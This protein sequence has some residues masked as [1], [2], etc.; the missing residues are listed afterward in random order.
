LRIKKD[1]VMEST[2]HR[3]LKEHYACGGAEV[4]VPLQKFR[5]DVMTD[6][7]LIEIQHSGLSAIQRKVATLLEEHQ[8][9]VVKPLI[10]RKRLLRRAKKQGAVVSNR[11]SPKRGSALDLFEELVHFTQVFPHPNLA[12]ETPLVT[13][14]EWRY[15][16]H[17]KRR[18]WRKNDFQ[19][20]DRKL[21][22]IESTL[23][24][25]SPCDLL[26]L[27]PKGLPDPFHTGH[28]AE[29]M[30]INRWVAQRIAYCLKNTGAANTVGKAGNTVLYSINKPLQSIA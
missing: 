6:E 30:N 7:C 24:F 3:Q 26:Q 10:L 14:E 16:G 5:I 8:V 13:I 19:V 18:R 23:R 17:G 9:L 27:L 2:L 4:E 29:A 12:I 21:V 1:S 22:E 25:E 11:L 15:P 28:L 20:E